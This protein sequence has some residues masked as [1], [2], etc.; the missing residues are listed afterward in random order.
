MQ[1]M[2]TIAKDTVSF[3]TLSSTADKNGLSDD[4]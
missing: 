2:C 1:E 4:L 3:I